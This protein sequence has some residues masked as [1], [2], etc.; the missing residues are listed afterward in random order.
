MK[1]GDL[2]PTYLDSELKSQNINKE[3]VLYA[4]PSDLDNY[5]YFSENWLILTKEKLVIL[6]GTSFERKKTGK[7]RTDT[8]INFT[9]KGVI[10]YLVSD[11]KKI[12]IN[13]MVSGGVL[14]ASIN[15]TEQMLC[16]FT[17]SRQK[18]F[19]TLAKIHGKLVNGEEINYEEIMHEQSKNVCPK[20][21][22][23][24]PDSA[25]KVCPNCMDKRSVFIRI[26]SFMGNYKWKVVLLLAFMLTSAAANIFRPYLSGNILFDEVL[27]QG[28]KYYGKIGPVVLMIAGAQLMFLLFSII[29][30]RI[31]AFVSTN[32]I[33]DIKVK[34][35]K[36]MQELS[37][38]FFNS[39]ETGGLLTRV[40]NDAMRLTH[41]FHDGMPYVVVNTF[42]LIGTLAVMLSMNAKLTLLI[43][44]PVPIVMYISKTIFPRLNTLHT[45]R[46]RAIR[47]LNALTN[48]TLTGFRVVKAFGKEKNE[49]KRFGNAN[50]YF[51]NSVVNISTFASTAFPIMH[52]LVST[53]TLIIWGFGGY[54]VIK[55]NMTFGSLIA[56]NMYLGMLYQPIQF[57]SDIVN[58]WSDTMT[59]GQR[60]FEICDAIPD[61]YE[62][63]NPKP[64]KAVLG[65]IQLKNITFSYQ[66]N[67]PVIHNINIDIQPGETIGLVGKSGAGKSTLANLITRLYDVEEGE[68]IIDGINIKDYSLEDLHTKVGMVMQD[69]FLF[70]GTVAENISYGQPDAKIANI[71]KASIAAG[72]HDFIMKLPDKYDTLIGKDGQD[73]SGGERQRLSIARTILH[74]PDVLILDEATASVDTETEIKIQN[75]LDMLIENKTTI[76]IAH[77]LSTLRSANRILVLD[78]GKIIESGSHNELLDLKG[79]F[80][81]MMESQRKALE[82]GGVIT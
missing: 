74:N 66:P 76:V 47:Y 82:I 68:I 24:Y 50:E 69:T 59:A 25:R 40:N 61:I 58:W 39:K 27:A 70:A 32:I 56:F 65:H 62:I 46:H 34:V 52:L 80:Y 38:S 79:E 33:Y 41:F 44:L 3:D 10:E 75:A 11:V 67:K 77:R 45:K 6:S 21:G 60:I 31:N 55:G 15:E 30:G 78:N 4:V 51:T 23:Y 63:E 35:F 8:D 28:G 57:M 49:I 48:D 9:L 72:A 14:I 19:G 26:L 17:A 54:Q 16:R 20:C 12:I 29:Q 81:S 2:L 18:D 5:G 42:V 36:A 7:K 22:R 43:L 13:D 71:I 37:M 53:G 1:A 64:L 73:L